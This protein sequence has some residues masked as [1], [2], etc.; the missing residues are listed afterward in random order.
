LRKTSIVAALCAA[1]AGAPLAAAEPG[2]FELE[3]WRAAAKLDV[4]EGYEN[5]LKQ[6]PAGAFSEMAKAALRRF[7][8]PE[9]PI[10]PPA[11]ALAPGTTPLDVSKLQSETASGAMTVL[12]G[13]TLIGPGIVSVGRFGAK[14]Q[15]VVP[16]G[17]W[18]VLD[19]FDHESRAFVTVSLS[20]VILA[21]M[22]GATLR[23]A[24]FVTFNS[25]SIPNLTGA[26]ANP[27]ISSQIVVWPGAAACDAAGDDVLAKT[28][29]T[30][31]RRL[32]TCASVRRVVAA[33]RWT[34]EIDPLLRDRVRAALARIGA[35]LPAMATRSDV[36][37]TEPSQAYLGYV[38]FDADAPSP[39]RVAWLETFKALAADG[40]R[41]DFVDEDLVDM[42]PR[43]PHS[44]E[45]A[46]LP[47]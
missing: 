36:Q 45:L 44:A 9:G 10:A 30:T 21:Q 15:L 27:A 3:L 14:R 22:H 29:E 28:V 8:A 43:P 7:P 6:F 42:T 23:S 32:R 37:M 33:D 46:G 17:R 25:R 4:K 16:R 26:A 12:P 41:R 34:S 24:L 11:A 5:Y 31:M 1:L 38:R 20:T 19:T 2:A 35:P 39:A 13:Q 47:D 40:Y 18:L